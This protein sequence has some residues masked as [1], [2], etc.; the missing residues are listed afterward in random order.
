[1]GLAQ[2]GAQLT[3]SLQVKQEFF[4]Q[5]RDTVEAIHPETHVE[6]ES[7]ENVLARKY[8]RLHAQL[9]HATDDIELEYSL[10]VHHESGDG[11]FGMA[12]PASHPPLLVLP[13]ADRSET[14]LIADIIRHTLYPVPVVGHEI[15]EDE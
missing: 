5:A 8:S 1:M 11:E 15:P 12:D 10:S 14:G 3:L 7:L 2:S 6:I 4:E 9:Q 13:L